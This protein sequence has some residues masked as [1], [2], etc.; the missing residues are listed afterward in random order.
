MKSMEINF[1]LHYQP[2]LSENPW[3]AVIGLSLTSFAPRK[4]IFSHIWLLVTP[5]I[6]FRFFWVRENPF[7]CKSDFSALALNR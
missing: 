6:D 2:N 4:W 7:E 1:G 3:C 5:K